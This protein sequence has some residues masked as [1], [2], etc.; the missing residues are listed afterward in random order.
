[1]GTMVQ[2]VSRNLEWDIWGVNWSGNVRNT[3]HCRCW[4]SKYM[5]GHFATGKSMHMPRYKPMQE[6][7]KSLMQLEDW[8]KNEG[9]DIN[10]RIQLMK[11]LQTWNS[12]DDMNNN[13]EPLM[14]KQ[15]S[16]RKQCIWNIWLSIEWRKQQDQI[17]KQLQSCKSSKHWTT[18]IIK[19]LWNMAWDMWEQRNE[20]LHQS[21]V[22][23]KPSS[24]KT[25]MTKSDRHMIV[26]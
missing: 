4:V 26:D 18:E 23:R 16:I 5:S 24:K 11:A 12:P 20:A 21:A 14:G 2:H 17:W 6:M 13:Q 8:L 19:K 15:N 22:N 10:I 3:N 25:S 9:M 1:M 7:E